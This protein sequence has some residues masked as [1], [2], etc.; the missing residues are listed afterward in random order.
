MTEKQFETD[1]GTINKND[2]LNKESK[3][4]QKEVSSIPGFETFFGVAGL[5]AVFL[6]KRK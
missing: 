4:E 6:H 1:N 5:L 2:T 3:T